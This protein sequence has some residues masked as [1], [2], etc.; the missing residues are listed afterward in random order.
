MLDRCLRLSTKLTTPVTSR[1]PALTH[2]KAS[3]M[4]CKEPALAC[5]I[6]PSAPRQHIIYI[7]PSR[8]FAA[9][10]PL[11]STWPIPLK[12]SSG[13]SFPTQKCPRT[14]NTTMPTN[15][16]SFECSTSIQSFDNTSSGPSFPTH[17][18][19]GSTRISYHHGS[20]LISLWFD[21][22]LLPTT[23]H[24][25]SHLISALRRLGLVCGVI[26]HTFTD[27]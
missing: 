15:I 25:A 23:G 19:L 6:L 4:C 24:Y 18:H 13:S 16:Q 17:H 27:K 11:V 9:D 12:S 8:P 22:A 14:F 20:T 1:H 21:G 3:S 26:C 10:T 7:R 5:P 2:E